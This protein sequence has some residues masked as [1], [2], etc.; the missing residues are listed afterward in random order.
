MK[1]R[2]GFVSNSSSSSFIVM[3]E[4]PFNSPA[5]VAYHMLVERKWL[6]DSQMLEKLTARL[7]NGNI[8]RLNNVC[9]R[10]INYD[11]YIY[12]YINLT[13]PEIRIYT[14]NNTDWNFPPGVCPDSEDNGYTTSQDKEYVMVDTRVVGIPLDDD[15]CD[16]IRKDLGNPCDFWCKSCGM[17]LWYRR[18]VGRRE[19]VCPCCSTIVYRSSGPGKWTKI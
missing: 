5:E 4:A 17:N 1:I 2:T 8:T 3:R 10:S 16:S 11:T 7:R 14:C 15:V 18:S 9:F 6:N 12:H 19:V 13:E